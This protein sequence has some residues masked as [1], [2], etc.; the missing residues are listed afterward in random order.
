MELTPLHHALAAH[1]GRE[2]TPEAAATILMMATDATDRSVD[3]ARFEP[4][5]HG[6]VVIG[7]ERFEQALAELHPLHLA[8]WQE[9]ERYRHA[10]G[11]F[12]DYEAIE[13]S[14]R[15]GLLV[16]FTA[17]EAGRLIG[18]LRVYIGK[19]RHTGQFFAQEDT[20]FVVPEN[21][22]SL[23]GIWLMRYA[24]KALVGVLGVREI[25]FDSKASNKADVLARRLKY[26]PV[27]TL[28]VKTFKE[29]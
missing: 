4:A 11:F 28:F 20:L 6:A 7:V 18:H 13:W 26:E 14:S 15:C 12:P 9:T 27:A 22:N 10:A 1:L 16:Q 25:R 21:R 2:L 24:E 3:P 19:S 5:T 8:Q 29:N 23:L 17:R